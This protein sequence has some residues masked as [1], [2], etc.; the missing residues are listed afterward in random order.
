[1]NTR[2]SEFRNI[3]SVYKNEKAVLHSAAFLRSKTMCNLLCLIV[4][5]G[6]DCFSPYL[7]LF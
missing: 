1:M 3:K 7:L 5:Y 4:L 2:F 6:V